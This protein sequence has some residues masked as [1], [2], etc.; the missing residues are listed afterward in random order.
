LERLV[1]MI[2]LQTAANCVGLLTT[3]HMIGKT[4]PLCN[5]EFR[6][7]GERGG[8]IRDG[9]TSTESPEGKWREVKEATHGGFH[10]GFLRP[11]YQSASP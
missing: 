9:Y 2:S 5:F 10:L 4:H 6:R 7:F 3:S 11:A 1:A 8:G